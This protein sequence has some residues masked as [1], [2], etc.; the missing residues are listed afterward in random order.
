MYSSVKF[1]VK[2]SIIID[3]P[4]GSL[5]LTDKDVPAGNPVIETTVVDDVVLEKINLTPDNKES[6]LPVFTKLSTRG[7]VI[8]YLVSNNRKVP[9]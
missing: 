9:L 7:L 5:K 2:P 8:L 3:L 4:L 6:L 1:Y